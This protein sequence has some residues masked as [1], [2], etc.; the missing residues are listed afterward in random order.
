MKSKSKTIVLFYVKNL[1]ADFSRLT[2]FYVVSFVLWPKKCLPVG[3]ISG[4]G[5]F[6][7]AKLSLPPMPT[8]PPWPTYVYLDTTENPLSVSFYIH[9]MAG[10]RDVNTHTYSGPRDFLRCM[11]A[12]AIFLVFSSFT[13]RSQQSADG[14]ARLYCWIHFESCYCAPE[15]NL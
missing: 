4:G 8:E 6:W 1:E 9:G 14:A 2:E 10:S 7:V 13:V 11:P 15:W 12:E 3:N 5:E